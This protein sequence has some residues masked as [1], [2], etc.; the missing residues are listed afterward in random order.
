L[1]NLIGNSAKFTKN[2]T[3]TIG[4]STVKSIDKRKPDMIEIYVA[5]TGIGIAEEDQKRLFEAFGKLDH[6]KELNA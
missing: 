2:G 4:A 6:G 3:I 1:I 5:D